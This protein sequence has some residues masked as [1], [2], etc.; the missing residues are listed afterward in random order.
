MGAKGETDTS[1][2]PDPTQDARRDT[3]S[4]EVTITPGEVF[5]DEKGH[6]FS[7]S[8]TA[9]GPMSGFTLT[10]PIPAGLQPTVAELGAVKDYL[11]LFGGAEVAMTDDTPP[12]PDVTVT[13]APVSSIAIVLKTLNKGQTVV[14]SYPLAAVTAGTIDVAADPHQWSL[15][16]FP[17]P[18]RL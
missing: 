12:V 17:T 13:G 2:P 15:R 14:V 8:F 6:R 9:P 11:K 4:R 18:P 16:V 10:I 3:A 7:I 5:V 1:T